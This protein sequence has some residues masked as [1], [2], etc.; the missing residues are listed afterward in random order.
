M[1]PV[2]TIDGPAGS[3]KSTISR[4][5]AKKLNLLYLDTGAMYRAVALQAHRQ[6]LGTDQAQLLRKM[7]QDMDLNFDRTSDPARIRQH[8]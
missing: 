5:L 1:K 8:F 6:D 4:Q 2:I 3:G 7:C